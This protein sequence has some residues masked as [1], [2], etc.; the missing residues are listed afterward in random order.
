MYLSL[1]STYNHSLDFLKTCKY[2]SGNYVSSVDSDTD[3]LVQYCHGSPGVEMTF[4]L[5]YRMTHKAEYLQEALSCGEI[6]W[7]RGLLKKGYGLCHGVAGNAYA[8]LDLYNLT[9]DQKW[10]HRTWMVNLIK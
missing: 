3:K 6:T 9:N 8:L 7:E 5:A 10:L 1:I 4:N 2:D